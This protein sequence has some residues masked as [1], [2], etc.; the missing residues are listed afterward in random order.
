MEADLARYYRIDLGDLWRGGLTLRRL[1]VLVRHLPPDAATMSE[2]GGDG[3]TLS[4][5]LQA[6]LVHATTGQPHPA[7]PRVRRAEEEKL[8]RLAEAQKRAERRRVEM[9]RRRGGRS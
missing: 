7:D 9:N 3:W 1:A 6:D 4:H 2:L 5:Y 8:A